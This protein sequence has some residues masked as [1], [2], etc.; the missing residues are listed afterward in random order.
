MI[1]SKCTKLMY[2]GK[3]ESK[4][5]GREEVVSLTKSLFFQMISQISCNPDFEQQLLKAVVYLQVFIIK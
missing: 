2:Y 1:A 3:N 4:D 5:R